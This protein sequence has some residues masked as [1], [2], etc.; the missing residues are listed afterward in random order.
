MVKLGASTFI[1]A[2]LSSLTATAAEPEDDHQHHNHDHQH[3]NHDH[4]DHQHHSHGAHVHGAWELFAALDD[5]QLS[6]TV[7][8]PIVDVLG[9]ETA[10]ASDEERKAVAD[11]AARLEEPDIMLSLDQR[12]DCKA[13]APV[14]VTL[15]EGFAPR[16]E[17]ADA[18]HAHDDHNHSHDHDHDHDNHDIHDSDVEVTYAFTCGAPGRLG[19]I[20]LTGFTTFSEI[21]T[22]DAVFLSDDTQAAHRLERRS[23]VLK[24]D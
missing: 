13:S 15:P 10:P 7:K 3:H 12:A 18:H 2:A 11:L 21:K 5:A 6:V 16:T 24:I 19:A 22:V 4:D 17:Q 8:G 1:F 23:Q 9:F 14:V 20:T